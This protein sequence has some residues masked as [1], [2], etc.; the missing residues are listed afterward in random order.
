MAKKVLF[1]LIALAFVL[2]IAAQTVDQ[3]QIPNVG[4]Q[5]ESGVKC[6][7]IATNSRGD[8][9]IVFRQK[10]QSI[11][12][13]FIKKSTGAVTQTKLPGSQDKDI[14]ITGCVATADDNFH[15]VWGCLIGTIGVFTADF[16]ITTET[17]SAPQ[18]VFTKYPEDS[19]IRVNPVTD[20]LVVC[21]ILRQSNNA[22]DVYTLFRK[23]GQTTWGNELN[24]TVMPAGKSATNPYAHFD[25]AGYLHVVWKEDSG[26]DNLIIRA[27]LI[28]KDSSGI[29][30]MVDK[31]WASSNSPG[32]HF[33]PSIAMTGTKGIIT[34]AWSQQSGYFYVPYERVGDTLVIDQS[35]IAKIVSAPVSPWYMF[36]S[37]A[38]AHGDE[39]MFTY[40]DMGHK[41]QLLRYK[42]G[43]W[44]D[45]TP[46]TLANMEINKAPYHL[47]ADPNLGLWATWFTEDGFGDGHSYYCLYNYPKPAIRPPV[48][49]T[50][51]RTM[52]RS[53]FHGYWMFG[54]KWENNP[55]NIAKNIKVIKFNI[56][57]RIHWSSAKWVQVGSVDGTVFSFGD[58]NGITATSDYEYGVT[59]VNEKN[60]ESR[61][62]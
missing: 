48:N 41:L 20:D 1:V 54:V 30:S 10:F 14:V 23:S 17:W 8:I 29:Y 3:F 56:Y 34:F 26:A 27:A 46:I 55:D 61:L 47:W 4:A 28:K 33:L 16:N 31:Q 12:Y 38:I 45:T 51:V 37:K 52:E 50:Y 43:V 25:E 39:I 44:L 32:W 60:I 36:H 21:V 6:P 9:M 7:S 59:A 57:R 24:L 22:K 53:L 5:G 49:V 15:C 58:K 19:H 42:D 11:M 35:K 2:P 40:F 13:Y 62:P 18:R